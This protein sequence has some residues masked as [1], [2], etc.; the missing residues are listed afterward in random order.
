MS[1]LHLF[2][3]DSLTL[4]I[5]MRYNALRNA[6]FLNAVMNIIILFKVIR[7]FHFFKILMGYT[8]LT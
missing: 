3:N 7:Y 8:I 6:F 5:V 2:C 1:F 4:V